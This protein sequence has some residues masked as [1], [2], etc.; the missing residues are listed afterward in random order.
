MTKNKLKDKKTDNS[1]ISDHITENN[2]IK[3][4]KLTPNI[5]TPY[6]ATVNNFHTVADDY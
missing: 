2:L 4:L 5:T 6:P 1:N 3:K